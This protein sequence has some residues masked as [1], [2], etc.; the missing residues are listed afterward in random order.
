MRDVDSLE[1]KNRTYAAS[2]QLVRNCATLTRTTPHRW[3]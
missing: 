3:H 2:E 1:R